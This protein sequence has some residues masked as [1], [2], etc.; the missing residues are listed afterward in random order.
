MEQVWINW[1][2]PYRLDLYPYRD[3]SFDYGIYAISRLWGNS[4]TLLYIGESYRQTMY[5]RLYSHENKWIYQ[6][7]GQVQ[8][9][10]GTIE[11]E[12]GC[13]I[14]EQRI[15]DIEAL[16][17]YYHQPV[18]NTANKRNYYGRDLT[19]T[20]QNQK[21]G[22]KILSFELRTAKKIF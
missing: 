5:D 18:H 10:F 21:V 16:M 20:S 9:N 15:K 12:D 3:A 19:W 8:V 4:P 11:L 14:S 2:G 22:P 7:R 6:Y 13:K 1:N 17:I